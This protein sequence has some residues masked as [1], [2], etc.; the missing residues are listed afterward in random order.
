MKADEHKTPGHRTSLLR[1][2]ITTVLVHGVWIARAA[3]SSQGPELRRRARLLRAGRG[4]DGGLAAGGERALARPARSAQRRRQHRAPRR[5]TG[6]SY[7]YCCCAREA[8]EILARAACLT[9]SD[10]SC[11][12]FRRHSC[13]WLLS[14]TCCAKKQGERRNGRRHGGGGKET[15]KEVVQFFEAAVLSGDGNACVQLANL[16]LN[17]GRGLAQDVPKAARL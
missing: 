17:G 15:D 2:G 3:L 4:A 6:I 10:Y 8:S 12:G 13:T 11:L 16:Y 7:R 9:T 14:P 5:A 1:I